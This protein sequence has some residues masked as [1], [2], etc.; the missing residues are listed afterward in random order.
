MIHHM[1]YHEFIL[2][3]LHGLRELISPE[4]TLAKYKDE[5][6]EFFLG[7][8]YL[9]SA[10]LKTEYFYERYILECDFYSVL[11]DMSKILT[12]SCQE[13]EETSTFLKATSN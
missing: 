10:I 9:Y 6:N 7:I 1:E 4:V 8:F 5:N 11:L 2:R 12:D 13:Y 3:S